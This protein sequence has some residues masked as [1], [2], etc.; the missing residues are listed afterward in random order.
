[1]H[2]P[3]LAR[4]VLGSRNNT[5]VTLVDQVFKFNTALL[6]HATDRP[7]AV[8]RGFLVL[9]KGDQQG[10][11]VLPAVR[12]RILNRLENACDLVFHVDST[13]TPDV[14]VVHVPAKGGMCPVGLGTRHHGD[15]VHVAHEHDGFEGGV[16][17][18]KRHQQRMIDKLDLARREHVRPRLLHIGAQV[19][20]RLPV[21][22]LGI[23]ARDGRK[24]QHAAQALARA[25]LVQIGKIILMRKEAPNLGHDIL[26]I[27]M[28]K[29][30]P[31]GAALQRKRLRSVI[32]PR[33][34]ER[35]THECAGVWGC[36]R[37]RPARHPRAPRPCP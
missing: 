35:G 21:H 16:G 5:V 32:C 27:V 20:E 14:G 23:H 3:A 33:D 17:T 4:A 26:S 6:E 19:V 28:T 8:L 25:G 11:S 2:K 30:A 34:S 15:H 1:M 7:R 37:A 13:A 10:T 12:Q 36:R 22:R 18:A 31:T 9:T 29:A 24:R